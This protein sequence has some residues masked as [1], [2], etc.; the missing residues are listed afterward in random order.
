MHRFNCGRPFVNCGLLWANG[1]MDQYATLYWGR[2]RPRP[3]CVRWRPSFPFP[4]RGTTAPTF[5][6]MSI[7]AKRL[8]GSRS[9]MVHTT[10]VA[11]LGS[12]ATALDGDPAPPHG[13]GHSCLHFRPMSVVTK[14]SPISATNEL[15]L[16]YLTRVWQ[17][18]IE[19]GPDRL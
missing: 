13:K 4:E 5:R 3:H 15:F 14:L 8:D 11:S 16:G 19:L 12:G 6:P 10:E 18:R 9:H 1:W 7:V 17:M 2:P